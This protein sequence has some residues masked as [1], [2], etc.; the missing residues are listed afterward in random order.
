MSGVLALPASPGSDE[1]R[2]ED[3]IIIGGAEEMA[4]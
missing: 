3:R 1:M 2:V 4:W